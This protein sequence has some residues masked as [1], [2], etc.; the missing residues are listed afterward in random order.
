MPGMNGFRM[1]ARLDPQPLI[2]FTTTYDRYA[3]Q[4]FAADSVDYLLKPIEPAQLDRALRKVE[5]IRRS[6]AAP[7]DLRDLLKQ[8]LASSAPRAEYIARIGDRIEFIAVDHIS[9]FFAGGKL[10]HAAASGKAYVVDSTIHQLERKL[11]PKKFVRIHRSIIVNLDY[12]QELHAW[13][14][15]RMLARLKDGRNTELA[16]ARDRV[17]DLKA[18]LGQ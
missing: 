7:P 3:L 14:G 18:R 12:L 6:A 16:V 2:I 11:D 5:R 10:T 15:G 1:L 13:F 4:A 17:R 9:H 8:A